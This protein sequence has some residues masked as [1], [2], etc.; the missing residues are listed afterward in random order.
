MT[1][2]A[3]QRTCP[4]RLK[5]KGPSK[6]CLSAV[7]PHRLGVNS[8]HLGNGEP[9]SSTN[10]LYFGNPDGNPSP[11]IQFPK[12]EVRTSL[13]VPLSQPVCRASSPHQ[14]VTKRELQAP[15]TIQL[16][17]KETA[18]LEHATNLTHI[19][20]DD[21][22][23]RNMLEN[24]IRECEIHAFVRIYCQILAVAHSKAHISNP[25]SCL[26]FFRPLDHFAR[27]INGFHRSKPFGQGKGHSSDATPD[28]QHSLVTRH[29]PSVGEVGVKEI[30][31]ITLAAEQEFV[32]GPF[33]PAACDV[34]VG[35][36]AG[37][38]VPFLLHL[39]RRHIRVRTHRHSGSD[40]IMPAPFFPLAAEPCSR[41]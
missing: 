4:A 22:N 40:N 25:Q 12:P 35:I 33:V 15:I 37:S 2:F 41:G 14:T 18:L 19:V 24:D 36:L 31:N 5:S 1:G 17:S 20:Q 10:I 29:K 13:N 32:F 30:P 8:N 28:L 6:L 7:H 21:R 23:F 34:M 3:G 26:Q 39:G 9:A 27:N 38:M 16:E 11:T